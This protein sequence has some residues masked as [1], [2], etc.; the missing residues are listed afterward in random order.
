MVITKSV[1][2]VRLPIASAATRSEVFQGV[3]H[4]L[5]ISSQMLRGADMDMVHSASL[6]HKTA[7]LDLLAYVHAWATGYP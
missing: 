1:W 7:L 6:E 4:V 5:Q 2:I 3:R